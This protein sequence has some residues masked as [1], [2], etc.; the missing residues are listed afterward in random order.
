MSRNFAAE[1]GN[2]NEASLIVSRNKDYSDFNL[3]FRVNENTQ[4]IYKVRD[5]QAVKQSVKNLIMTNYYEVPFAP[6]QGSNIRSLLFE[7]SEPF[8]FAEAE[9]LIR[10]CIAKDEPRA[11]VTSV[12][13]VSSNNGNGLDIT[14]SFSIINIEEQFTVTVQVERLR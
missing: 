9:T 4:D 14:V 13:I 3:L 10:N 8:V 6:F 1:D 12:D 5:A 11:K 7:N 2:L